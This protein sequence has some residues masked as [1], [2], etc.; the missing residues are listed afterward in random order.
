MEVTKT[1]FLLLRETGRGETLRCPLQERAR[2]V[3]PLMPSQ[4]YPYSSS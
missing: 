1:V 4:G 3:S 2:A